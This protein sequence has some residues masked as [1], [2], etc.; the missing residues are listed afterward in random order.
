L[1]NLVRPETDVNNNFTFP[2]ASC[3]GHLKMLSGK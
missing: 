1:L 2:W 3:K